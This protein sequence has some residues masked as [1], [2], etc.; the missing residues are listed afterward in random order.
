VALAVIVTA[1]VQ[2]TIAG[3]GLVIASVPGAGLLAAV[4]LIFHLAQ[5]GPWLVMLPVTAWKF[6]NGDAFGGLVLLAFTVVAGTIDNFLRPLLIRKGADLPL[7]LIFAGVIGGI[8]SFGFM[9]IFVG[10]VI[11]AVS[12]VLLRDWVANEQKAEKAAGA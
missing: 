8:I 5:L 12:F 2:T 7:L 9:G 3:A 4:T 1:S 10:P 6:Y 11:F